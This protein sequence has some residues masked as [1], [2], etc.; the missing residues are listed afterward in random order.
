MKSRS[1]SVGI[2]ASLTV[3]QSTDESG[4]WLLHVVLKILK[5]SSRARI[6]QVPAGLQGMLVCLCL[7]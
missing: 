2:Q 3:V 5:F 1:F 4:V 7:L 6:L